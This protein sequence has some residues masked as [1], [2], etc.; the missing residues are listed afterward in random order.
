MA[1]SPKEVAAAAVSA[2]R[3]KKAINPV[4]LDIKD[5]SVICDYFIIC[6]GNSTTQVKA[7][8][9]HI[10]TKLKEEGLPVNRREGLQDAHWILLDYGSVVVHIFLEEDRHFYNLERLWSDAKVVD[11]KAL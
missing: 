1:L 6:S 11:I 8:A 4:L 10:E 3:D 7:L 5:I 2:A 9:E